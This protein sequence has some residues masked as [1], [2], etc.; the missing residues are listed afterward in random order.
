M[1]AIHAIETLAIENRQKIQDLTRLHEQL[2]VDLKI[3]LQQLQYGIHE[4][5]KT[6]VGLLG[7]APIRKDA[8]Q[9]I[10]AWLSA[11]EASNTH[12]VYI[13]TAFIESQKGKCQHLRF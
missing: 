9:T 13:P 1:R 3:Q 10:S 12:G 5:L 8:P 2:S 7:N 4:V 6:Q 11:A